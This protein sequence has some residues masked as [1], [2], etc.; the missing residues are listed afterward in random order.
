MIIFDVYKNK[1]IFP[2]HDDMNIAVM[3][4]NR[5]EFLVLLLFNII[6]QERS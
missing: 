1:K 6:L 2:M 3:R 5:N 4:I